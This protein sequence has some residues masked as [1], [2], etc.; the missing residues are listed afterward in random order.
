[1]PDA[2][3]TFDTPQGALPK[4]LQL[5]I[6]QIGV[7]EPANV[8]NGGTP[9]IR[10]MGGRREP[11]CSHFIAW[12]FREAG[13]PL[14]G[15][16]PA[17][18]GPPFG[19]KEVWNPL[20][21]VAELEKVCQQKGW[22]FQSGV[23]QSGDIVFLKDRGSSDKGPQGRHVGLVYLVT[24]S[25]GGLVVSSIDGNWKNQVSVVRRQLGAPEIA[26][27]ARVKPG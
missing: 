17:C 9:S 24:P 21:S 22:Y 27:Y 25:S 4:H 2:G 10:Y 14:P 5:A 8:A 26:G 6:T 13:T 18:A 20:A 11:W 16:K 7:A 3:S 12:C 15:D 19:P 1:M 23:P